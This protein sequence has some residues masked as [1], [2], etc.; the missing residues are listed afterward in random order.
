MGEPLHI[1]HW[2]QSAAVIVGGRPSGLTGDL[3]AEAGFRVV[4]RVHAGGHHEVQ[5]LTGE[6]G[7]L[8]HLDIE[9]C[10]E[11]GSAGGI[12]GHVAVCRPTDQVLTGSCCDVGCLKNEVGRNIELGQLRHRGGHAVHHHRARP[13][14]PHGSHPGKGPCKQRFIGHV[15]KHQIATSFSASTSPK[16]VWATNRASTQFRPVSNSQLSTAVMRSSWSSASVMRR[17]ISLMA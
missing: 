17:L 12:R 15:F 7:P 4:L 1:L 16:M 6:A 5:V 3:V 14:V 9:L 2:N 13:L 11:H 10:P 8:R